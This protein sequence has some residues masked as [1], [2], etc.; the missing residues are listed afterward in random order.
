MKRLFFLFLLLLPVLSCVNNSFYVWNYSYS[1]NISDYNGIYFNFDAIVPDPVL[2]MSDVYSTEGF[3]YERNDDALVYNDTNQSYWNFNLKSVSSYNKYVEYNSSSSWDE[4][5]FT[6]FKNVSVNYTRH[7]YD[8]FEDGNIDDWTISFAPP[9]GFFLDSSANAING[10]ASLVIAAS[11]N[12]AREKIMNQ[13]DKG[14]AFT[15]RTNDTGNV[16]N[17]KWVMLIDTVG[18]HTAGV[19]K[20]QD[21]TRKV[22]YGSNGGTFDSGA[23][24]LEGIVHSIIIMPEWSSKTYSVY[25]DGSLIVNNVAFFEPVIA[26]LTNSVRLWMSRNADMVYAT[27]DDF[28]F[29]PN[30]TAVNVSWYHAGNV[31]FDGGYYRVYNETSKA[32]F[33]HSGYN[34][35]FVDTIVWSN[36]LDTFENYSIFYLN[37]SV[38]GS[39][40]SNYPLPVNFSYDKSI[41]E[42]EVNDRASFLGNFLFV[43]VNFNDLVQIGNFYNVSLLYERNNTL[44]DEEIAWITE[45]RVTCPTIEDSINITEP[46]TTFIT[47]EQPKWISARFQSPEYSL[48][49]YFRSVLVTSYF[50]DIKLFFLEFLED[51]FFQID[52]KLVYDNSDEWK[53]ANIT[54]IRKYD[55]GSEIIYSMTADIEDKVVTF[56]RNLQTYYLVITGKTENRDFGHFIPTIAATKLIELRQVSYLTGSSFWGDVVFNFTYSE[57]FINFRFYDQASTV[58]N[59]SWWVWNDS[60]ADVAYYVSTDS[61]KFVST[62]NAS[63]YTN[64]TLIVGFIAAS[65]EFGNYT[66]NMTI[67]IGYSATGFGRDLIPSFLDSAEIERGIFIFLVFIALTATITISPFISILF[68]GLIFI[69]KSTGYLPS[70]TIIDLGLFSVLMLAGLFNRKRKVGS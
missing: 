10:S 52:F 1:A 66:Y 56:L 41:R 12:S 63:D 70:V 3:P 31:T 37:D 29:V 11:A 27:Y 44:V 25:M 67:N 51:P 23:E 6:L 36:S 68:Y 35:T 5:L 69:F 61:N 64:Q 43:T 8:R 49:E 28:E 40:S 53:N 54:V 21:S 45:L 65:N 33:N 62:Y 26:R 22:R 55:E 9:F 24:W 7:E 19:V 18:G 60:G 58:Y 15:I 48:V 32:L 20:F 42:W 13:F 17:E 46:Y 16:N 2:N 30:V 57:P 4:P 39:D 59:V 50:E 34:S 38:V 47:D 14:I